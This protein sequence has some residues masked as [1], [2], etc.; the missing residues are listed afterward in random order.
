M[1]RAAAAAAAAAATTSGARTPP[2]PHNSTQTYTWKHCALS[3]QPERSAPPRAAVTCADLS[4]GGGLIALC[5]ARIIHIFAI[6]HAQHSDAAALDDDTGHRSALRAPRA[7]ATPP[8]AYD[9]AIVTRVATLRCTDEL[10]K[11]SFSPDGR[12]L[13]A[14]AKNGSVVKLWYIENEKK[15]TT[16]TTIAKA[17]NH[18]FLLSGTAKSVYRC[19]HYI[20]RNAVAPQIRWNSS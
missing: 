15:K 9:A 2:S 20:F 4:D 12:F 19:L 3:W 8:L 6:A 16:T 13:A 7:A 11:V 1:A 10:A 14:L 18:V 17:N 5:A